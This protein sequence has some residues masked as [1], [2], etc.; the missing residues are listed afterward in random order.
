MALSRGC[1]GVRISGAEVR[2][3][4][5]RR[6]CKA[7]NRRLRTRINTD[8]RCFLRSLP[9]HVQLAHDKRRYVADLATLISETES[10]IDAADK[11]AEEERIKALDPIAS[12]DPK[13]AREAMQAAEFTET[14]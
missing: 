6:S 3:R 10:A 2:F 1:F 7:I 13:A 4:P 11:A 9:A 12:P 14:G 8:T 5:T